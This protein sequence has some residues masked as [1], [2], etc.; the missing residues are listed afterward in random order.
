MNNVGN[1]GFNAENGLVNFTGSGQS[2]TGNT[3]FYNFTKTVGV[4]DTL[5]FAANSTQTFANGGTM[6]LTGSSGNYLLLRS[7]V[8]NSQWNINPSGSRNIS[9]LDVEDSN[10]IN[11]T[12]IATAGLN[13]IDS[14]DNTNWGLMFIL[15]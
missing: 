4:N 9:Y 2:I 13:I 5:T 7:S 6:T 12:T 11:E 15:L 1:S 8:N 10:N 3:T 14:G